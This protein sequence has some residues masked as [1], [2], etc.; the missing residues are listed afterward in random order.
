MVCLLSLCEFLLHYLSACS[1]MQY[2]SWSIDITTAFPRV[3]VSNFMAQV[4]ARQWVL[5]ATPSHWPITTFNTL[6]P[7]SISASSI[8]ALVEQVF[9]LVFVCLRSL[10]ISSFPTKP[11]SL[12][13]HVFMVYL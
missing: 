5:V 8:S 10:L 13:H 3:P 9:V 7:L 11:Y 1:V 12:V 6:Y 4:I 2:P